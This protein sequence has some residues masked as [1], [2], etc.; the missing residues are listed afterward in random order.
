MSHKYALEIG[1]QVLLKDMGISPQDVLR[2]AR[3]PLDLLSRKS[4]T[5]SD[6]EYFRLWDGLTAVMPHEPSFPLRLAQAFSVETFSPPIFACF[7]STNLNIALKRL[8]YYKPLVGPLRLDVQQ[9]SRQTTVT[10]QGL[11]AKDTIP[12]SLIAFEFA[13]WVHIA[14]LATR[15]HIIP[16]SVHT[17]V[18][19]P[20]IADY[21]DYLGTPVQPDTFNGIRFSADD[22]E[23]PFL[24]ASESMWSIFEPQLNL[25]M[26]DLEKEAKFR[27]RVRASLMETLASGQ[28]SMADVASR[29]AVSTRTLQRRL[30]DEDTSFQ[31]E[32]DNLREE[33]ALHYLAKSDYSS[34]QIAFLLGYQD[35]NSFF[36]A[37]RTWTGQTPEF[38]RMDNQ[39]H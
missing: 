39:P 7:C 14:R 23:K 4:P 38:A 21:E 6:D 37:F 36:R 19:I 17:T 2:H 5:V 8:T 13:F 15:E 22:A 26:Q 3:L 29:L 35:P 11:P 30:R 24:T 16:A 12:P 32:L 18:H 9:N 31:K 28:Y 25:R 1:W 27:D 34:G 20:Q 10:F 33:L